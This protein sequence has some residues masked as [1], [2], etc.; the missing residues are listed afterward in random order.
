MVWGLG[1]ISTGP[2]VLGCGVRVI[3]TC[4]LQR[5]DD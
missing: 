3:G 1:A 2:Y 4:G 5:N